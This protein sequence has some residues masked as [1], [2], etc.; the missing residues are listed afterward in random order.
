[1]LPAAIILALV[2]SAP[3]A[4]VTWTGPLGGLWSTGTNWS[5]TPTPPDST[6]DV[7]FTS[8]T[9]VTNTNVTNEVG[10]GITTVESLAYSQ[11]GTSATVYHTTQ[12]D[13]TL[14]VAGYSAASSPS[15]ANGNIT[16][17][18]YATA[19]NTSVIDDTVIKGGG[20]LDL[21]NSLGGNTNGD[22][23]VT[24]NSG[25][26]GTRVG[27]LDLTGLS[28]FN[29]NVDQ[30]LIGY[31]QGGTS[32]RPLGVMYLAQSNTITLNNTTGVS[33]NNVNA[34]LVIGYAGNDVNSHTSSLY[35][36]QTNVINVQNVVVGG[37]R[38]YGTMSFNP[39]FLGGSTAPTLVMRGQTGT[40]DSRV[41]TIS[42]GDLSDAGDVSNR[43]N[44][45][46]DL[47][48][49]HV[50][51][52]VD[53]IYLGKT[54]AASSSRNYAVP[55]TLNFDNGTID[56]TT[57]L[58]GDQTATNNH[59]SQGTIS[60]SGTGNLI[61]GS[62]GLTLGFFT[63][64]NGSSNASG[65]LNIRNSATVSSTAANI[66]DGG[67]NSVISMS[68]TSTLNMGGHNIG[69]VDNPIDSFT[70]SG[71]TINDLGALAMAK[72]YPRT[73]FSL[74]ASGG[75]TI[76]AGGL[77]DMRNGG[78]NTFTS[79]NLTLKGSATM[80][81]EL[82]DS[83]SGTNDQ[84]NLDSIAFNGGT[85]SVNVSPLV[86]NFSTGTYALMKFASQ[87]ASTPGYAIS[88]T[89][90]NTYPNLPQINP[91]AGGGYELDLW[92]ISAGTPHGLT[93]NGT[94]TGTWDLKTTSNW[95]WTSGTGFNGLADKYYDLDNVTFGDLGATT[96][97]TV[98]NSGGAGM[99]PGSVTVSSDH[100]YTLK[101]SASTDK[102]SGSTGITKTGSGTLTISLTNDYTGATH[103]NG[104][105]I[106]LGNASSLGSSSASVYVN[107]GTLDLNDQQLGG[108]PK[109]VYIQGTGMLVGGVGIGAIV[110]N[111]T[112][113][114]G[115]NQYDIINLILTGNATIGGTST[116][117][118][119]YS[120]LPGGNVGLWKVHGPFGSSTLG[121]QGAYSL[122]KVG[123]NMVWLMNT[124]TNSSFLNLNIN[125]GILGLDGTTSL[126][127]PNGTIT[128]DGT[129]GGAMLWLNDVSIIL[130]KNVV[131][132]GGSNAFIHARGNIAP[133]DNTI[134]GTVSIGS[135]GGFG[136]TIDTGSAQAGSYSSSSSARLNISGVIQNYGG[137]GGTLI[138]SGP[139]TLNV[140]NS[141]N[142]F[143]GMT[144]LTGGTLINTGALLGGVT[145]STGTTLVGTGSFG[146]TV[147]DAS[148]AVI[149]PGATSATGSVGT[150]AMNNLTLTGGG[151]INYDLATSSGN[152]LIS[153]G[154][155]LSLTG[156]TEINIPNI[157]N[158]ASGTYTLITCAGKSGGGGFHLLNVP[159][160]TRRLF[161]IDNAPTTQ[162]TYSLI[163]TAA[164]LEWKGDGGNNYWDVVTTQNWLNNAAPDIFYNFDGVTFNDDYMNQTV[165]LNQDV[166]PSSITVDSARTYTITGQHKITGTTGLTKS[167]SGTLILANGFSSSN[168]F[169]GP[170]QI[171]LGTLQV[172]DG[173]T[174]NAL[175]GTGAITNNGQLLFIQTESHTV[176]NAIS[177]TGSVEQRGSGVLTLSGSNSYSGITTIT[178]G[179]LQA[180]S[181]TAL[182]TT[183]GGTTIADGATLDVNNMNLGDE[184][185]TV[186][187]QGVNSAGA[188]VNNNMATSTVAQNALRF[189]VLTGDTT[190][191]GQATDSGS[192][193]I[194]NSGRWEIRG[195]PAELATI[196]TNGNS[197]N[198]TKVGNNQVS[199]V[200]LT[201]DSALGDIHIGDSNTYT[202]GGILALIANTSVGDPAK[203]ITVA[204]NSTLQ[205][206]GLTIPL[207]K[208][209]SLDGGTLYANAISSPT[210]TDN[211]ILGTVTITNNGGTL[212]TG[213]IR[214]DV[215]TAS[216]NVGMII[217]GVVSSSSSAAI[218]TKM[219]PGTVTLANANNTF[220]GTVNL[221]D[222]T[223][224]VNGSLTG[225]ITMAAGTVTTTL[226]GNGTILGA[227]S[228]Y[229][230]TNI[231]PGATAGVGSVGIL[232]IGGSG[233]GLTLGGSGKITMDLSNDPGN[234]DLINVNGPLNVAAGVTNVNI[235]IIGGYL[236]GSPGGTLY[237]L[238]HY[239]SITGDDS[240]FAAP[241]T[242]SRQTYSIYKDDSAMNIDLKV[243]GSA[244]NL[245]WH[246][247][248]SANAW[249]VKTTTNW[250]GADSKFW[251]GDQVL[252]DDSSPN[253]TVNIAPATVIPGTITVSSGHNYI[254]A[255]TG[256]ISGGT[257]LTK[258]GTGSLTI[259]TSNTYSGPTIINQGTIILGSANALGNATGTI[260]ING[261]TQGS[262]GGTL[263]LNTQQLYA[264]PIIVQGVGVGGNGAIINGNAAVAPGAT[265]YDVSNVTLIGN[266]TI[267]GTSTTD[268]IYN[269][270]LPGS[271]YVGR[272]SL[273][274]QSGVTPVL[275]TNGHAYTLTKVG[276]NQIML[277]NVTADT[278]LGDVFVNKGVLSLE[279]TTS[280]GN[281]GAITV[282]GSALGQP[283]GGSMLQFRNLTVPLSKNVSLQN[284]GQIYS[285]QNGSDT[286]TSNTVTGTVTIGST[287]GQFNAGGVRADYASGT[288]ANSSAIMTIQGNIIGTG[289]LT[290]PGPGTVFITSS[291][292]SYSGNTTINSGTLQINSAP[293][294][295]VALHAVS[296]SGTLGI[297][298]G[299]ATSVTADSVKTGT[300][301]IGA[302]ATLTIN[303]IPGGPSAGLGP[304]SPVP[305]PATWAM[306]M[307]AAMGLGIYWRRR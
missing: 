70:I 171:N 55:G 157:N 263:D 178:T 279:G 160:N 251:T 20:T 170:I 198:I 139:G 250:T 95:N 124:T 246:G 19:G 23:I 68:G 56:A 123:N 241:S 236:Q 75:T 185:V 255:G 50:D 67:G 274:A 29:A 212:N 149:S 134:S 8:A 211:T 158:I 245:T 289:S 79:G 69:T 89:T 164:S 217:N 14:K 182:G 291:T 44:G 300:L 219:G 153:L 28:S 161:T 175:I 307:L 121:S 156:T 142:T 159:Q 140:T 287:G 100:D 53:T 76:T 264:Q 269:S 283:A 286:S 294:A 120:G 252:F 24:A 232:N 189:V 105:K 257:S 15:W 293:G 169:S 118:S 233:V 5:S 262:P 127:D 60:V 51:I 302:G 66:V 231:A 292:V 239:A 183:A 25:S 31:S 16:L 197:Y 62:P 277:I 129:S 65:T 199:F 254:F 301:T 173:S 152:D 82:S 145:M 72:F 116:T 88:D 34:G 184:T 83:T 132:T 247:D 37:Q 2:C 260:T 221:N 163:G 297:G 203:T 243:V 113:A 210:A 187:G 49:G 58:C 267:G 305:E 117:N 91:S 138:K 48:G 141:G 191:G 282:D 32:S 253:L 128:V 271:Q 258:S 248:G 240:N 167:G 275:S 151:Q 36:G 154:G 196:N 104:G 42:I 71:G 13:G 4:A 61:I 227:V 97:I 280:L 228:D 200:R 202:P 119:T 144:N 9:A 133:T 101:G 114:P 17:Y 109:A 102:I 201:A 99:V 172:G 47:T 242:D 73:T 174:P 272:W 306:L 284:N 107:G 229:Y 115:S 125:Q 192:G 39:A 103:I 304:I 235:N 208:K 285:L 46:M 64:T 126:G 35:L 135:T 162:V 130:N 177:G 26:D 98:S 193:P 244:A 213:G 218:L 1:M 225:G 209:I 77:I 204:Y 122:T 3:G 168:D 131:L 93:W 146:G 281:S 7:S 288:G 33:S 276:N 278:A 256:S 137:S 238:I 43:A 30:I 195:V 27:E 86:G 207:A 224:I 166:A 155:T 230:S 249:D 194:A 78:A 265:Q 54:A 148:G 92:G 59:N 223:L 106:I 226:A 143:N 85:L 303:A 266:T 268:T 40:D 186:Q 295:T 57:I 270:G 181:N 21:S 52:K 147:T 176:A 63:A 112:T 18:A 22:I 74:T 96:T 298:N 108:T 80:Y 296:G 180:G 234:S 94:T 214:S 38:Q 6:S 273:R 10:S 41:S 136:G 299:A 220:N 150:L 259:N 45:T 216:A 12:I 165:A 90:R 190:F 87:P 84:I 110:N 237:P 11:T 111:A 222:G 81:F 188:I 261:G 179:T 290:C 215:P 206:E 205:L